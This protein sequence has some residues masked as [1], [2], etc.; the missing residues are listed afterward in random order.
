VGRP[1]T[2]VKGDP[3]C[4]RKGRPKGTSVTDVLRKHG[5][6]VFELKSGKKMSRIEALSLA[7]WEL[8][9][10][11]RDPNI[12]K[13]IVDRFDGPVK[14]KDESIVIE[15]KLSE[16]LQAH[17]LEGSDEVPKKAGSD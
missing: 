8:A 1:G 12:I 13:W 10:V 11:H 7:A 17:E 6:Q 15:A 4:N 3:R 5:E 14:T 16:W 2:F 9:L